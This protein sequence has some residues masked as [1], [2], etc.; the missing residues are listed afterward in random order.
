MIFAYLC[1][2]AKNQRKN[3]EK[4]LLQIGWAGEDQG[5]ALVDQ[6]GDVLTEK[7]SIK[8]NV[9]FSRCHVEL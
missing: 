7:F 8:L 4:W 1:R 6:G 5:R 9:L 3:V 2:K